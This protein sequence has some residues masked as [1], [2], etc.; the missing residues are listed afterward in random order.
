MFNYLIRKD[1]RI[2]LSIIA[3]GAIIS[4]AFL[5]SGYKIASAEDAEEVNISTLDE[6]YDLCQNWGG[7]LGLSDVNEYYWDWDANNNSVCLA[8]IALVVCVR[9]GHTLWYAHDVSVE[10]LDKSYCPRLLE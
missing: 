8:N 10:Q 6:A 3:I 1:L 9:Q 4:M 2:A 5:F 7:N